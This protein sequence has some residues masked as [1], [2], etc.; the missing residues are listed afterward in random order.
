MSKTRSEEI[1]TVAYYLSR[2]S[3][4]ASSKSSTQ[5][6][7]S[8]E[9]ESWNEAYELFFSTLSD[10]RSLV[11]F[12]NTLKN[13]RD[14][15]DGH[16]KSGRTGWRQD[17]LDRKPQPLGDLSS[18]VLEK[19][20]NRT[21]KELADKVVA[22]IR[23][24]DTET[25]VDL[26]PTPPER[27]ATTVYRILRDTEIARKI[28]M[29]HRYKCQVC[30]VAIALPGGSFYAEAHHIQPLGAPH[31]G[32]DISEN[33]LC[34]CPNHHAEMDYGVREIDLDILRLSPKHE[35]D[36]RYVEYHNKEI[37]KK[38]NQSCHTTPAS[39]PR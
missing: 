34:L 15:Y 29:I 36:L 7:Q 13:A 8:L 16:T 33:I 20:K 4:N 38:P 23:S 27:V 1:W 5:P 2:C 9:V 24:M 26:D 10:G 25:P 30:G 3:V 21:D 37:N 31:N 19:W 12:K 32:P 14:L 6:P 18:Q 39:A 17:S 28:K 35:V 22:F 11:A